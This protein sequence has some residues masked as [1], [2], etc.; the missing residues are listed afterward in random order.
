MAGNS[1][2]KPFEWPLKIEALTN[3]SGQR[4]LDAS[5]RPQAVLKV[6]DTEALPK[7][8]EKMKLALEASRRPDVDDAINRKMQQFSWRVYSAAFAETIQPLNEALI[9]AKNWQIDA[10]ATVLWIT[11]ITPEWRAR[12]EQSLKDTMSTS[13]IEQ[14]AGEQAANKARTDAA[15]RAVLARAEQAKREAELRAQWRAAA[16]TSMLGGKQ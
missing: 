8:L 16:L 10:L 15:E 7:A 13:V 14:R 6:I 3:E 9:K 5:N 2:E 11:S 1:P 4:I 12:V